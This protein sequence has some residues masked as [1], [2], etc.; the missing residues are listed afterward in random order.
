[1]ARLLGV[2]L[3][4]KRVGL[5]VSD[6]VGILATPLRVLNVTSLRDALGQVAAAC[7]EVGAEGLGGWGLSPFEDRV[8]G[9]LLTEQVESLRVPVLCLR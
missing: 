2:D 7:R 6:P 9:E 1:M 8:Q 3:G 4:E 5:A